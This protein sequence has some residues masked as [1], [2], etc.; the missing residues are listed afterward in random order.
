MEETDEKGGRGGGAGYESEKERER[1]REE[2]SKALQRSGGNTTGEEADSSSVSLSRSLTHVHE[3]VQHRR[4][5]KIW[6]AIFRWCAAGSCLTHTHRMC[7]K[8]AFSH[9][10][11]FSFF[12]RSLE[13][14]APQ[15]T[16]GE[17]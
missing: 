13:S 8:H 12:K 11:F 14:V 17:V 2:S 10:D 7:F 4:P 6:S 9:W 1:D 15:G 16:L 5:G 3:H